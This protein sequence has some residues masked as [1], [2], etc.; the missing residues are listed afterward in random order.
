MHEEFMHY[1]ERLHLC[2]RSRHNPFCTSLEKLID[3]LPKVVDR[4][5]NLI[6]LPPRPALQVLDVGRVNPMKSV[7]WRVSKKN[8]H[9]D[10]QGFVE[11]LDL[12]ILLVLAA[13]LVGMDEEVD[14]IVGDISR[15]IIAG[16]RIRTA[17]KIG[18]IHI[19]IIDI[20]DLY[21]AVRYG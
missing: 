14:I 15:R 17:S 5:S 2:I 9:L 7:K 4:E 1:R 3:V 12:A 21:V 10:G 11:D 20:D 18:V 19:P 6:K 13:A 8:L 16:V